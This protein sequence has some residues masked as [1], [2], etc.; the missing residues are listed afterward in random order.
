MLQ[1]QGPHLHQSL[2]PA[3]LAAGRRARARRLGQHQGDPREG[4]RRDHRRDEEVGP[5]RPRR[6]RL[7]D[8]PEMVVHAEAV[9]RP[10]ALS[11]GQRR[12]V[13]ARHLQGPRHHAAR[14]AQA[15]R[16]L[17]GRRLRDGRARRLHLHP[18]RVLQRGAA[19]CRRRS[20]R[21]MRPA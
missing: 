12:R 8:R 14:S 7:P 3:R 16:G 5:A 13:R 4:P 6:R 21:P 20:T 15:G 9:E 1:R 19:C 10:A 18:R 11:R 2:R 17:P